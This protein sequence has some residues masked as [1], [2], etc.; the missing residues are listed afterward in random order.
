M[1]PTY[2]LEE[3][4]VKAFLADVRAGRAG[5]Q[6]PAGLRPLLP[7]IVKTVED[8]GVEPL[9][10]ADPCYGACDPADEQARQMGCDALLHY[11]HSDMGIRTS[12]PTLYVEARV[13]V[14]PSEKVADALEGLELRRVGLISTVQHAWALGGIA[15]LLERTGRTAVI[16]EPG[17]RVRYP[18]QVLGCDLFCARSIADRVDGFL[19]IGTGAFHPLGCSLATGKFTAAVNPLTGALSEF[20]PDDQGFV[21]KRIAMISRAALSSNFGVV[22]CTKPGQNRISLAREIAGRLRGAG[23]RAHL[24][25]MNE[26]NP[27][28]IMDFGLDAIVCTACPRIATDDSGRFDIPVLTPFE[29]DVMLGRENISPYKIDELG[30]DINPRKTIGV[31]QRWLK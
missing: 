7:E 3:G 31:G 13:P 6:I 4:R 24:L 9:V 25:I 8:A 30:R 19:Y 29:A 21:R 28:E 14:D 18:G 10:L 11:G 1:R 16:S 27:E 26:V 5:I 17:P 12:L 15:E 22:A 2:D 23:K 20:R